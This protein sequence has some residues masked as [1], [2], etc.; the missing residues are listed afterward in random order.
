MLISPFVPHLTQSITGRMHSP[1]EGPMEPPVCS[2]ETNQ[3]PLR[4]VRLSSLCMTAW[5]VLGNLISLEYVVALLQ[6]Y[7][8]LRPRPASMADGRPTTSGLHANRSNS[9][10]CVNVAEIEH[11]YSCIPVLL[12]WLLDG[13]DASRSFP[14]F[15]N[16]SHAQTGFVSISR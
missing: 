13:F 16:I 2:K 7:A 9:H 15:T 10:W 5:P 8:G 4:L 1:R 11:L 3:D 12:H 6:S 14:P